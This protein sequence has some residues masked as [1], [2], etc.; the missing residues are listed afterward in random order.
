MR[1]RNSLGAP[2]R[3]FR[4]P[5]RPVHALPPI[6]AHRGPRRESWAAVHAGFPGLLRLPMDGRHVARRGPW[7]STHDAR[8]SVRR[9]TNYRAPRVT[10]ITRCAW[11]T[12]LMNPTN[13]KLPC[14]QPA[15]PCTS[16]C[17]M[18]SARMHPPFPSPHA[19]RPRCTP[20]RW[21]ERSA[22]LPAAA[23][24]APG[25]RN[26]NLASKSVISHPVS[27]KYK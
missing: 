6:A 4:A 18:D 5:M 25:R 13:Q 19:S 27:E 9:R 26:S 1:A 21:T 3:P 20:A 10:G 7:C 2:H 12:H 16:G 22:P 11:C 15:G 24:A 14:V 23:R 8:S 17:S